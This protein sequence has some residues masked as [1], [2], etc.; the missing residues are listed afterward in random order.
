MD[1]GKIIRTG[2][3]KLIAKISKEGFE[4]L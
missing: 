3:H 4:K 1:D 2:D